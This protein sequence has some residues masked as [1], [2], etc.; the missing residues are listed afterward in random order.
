[1]S[2]KDSSIFGSTPAS[3]DQENEVASN[4]QEVNQA[5]AS[6]ASPWADKLQA[7]KTDDGRPK[8]A[9]V[10]DA[11][12]GL[13][14]SQSHISKLERENQEMR[15]LVKAMEERRQAEERHLEERQP[16]QEGGI[17]ANQVAELVNQTLSQRE[18]QAVQ[19]KNVQTV[20]STLTDKFGSMEAAEK[21]YMT[22]A[23]EMGINMEMMN[24][25][26]AHSPNA[27]LAYFGST[28]A[29]APRKTEGTINTAG[30][31]ESA[32]PRGKNPLLTG[33]IKDMQS[34]VE[35]IKREL[36]F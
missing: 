15:E 29:S 36:G 7:I 21:A 12:T 1:M 25:L 8:Y 33:S 34:E 13:E 11:L 31:R 22:K 2:D 6:D 26:A 30:I 32:T 17:D 20:V 14:H 28:G 3:P 23:Q 16:R 35:R 24:S 5:E 27:V 10:E 9:S 4:Q 18:T 19:Q